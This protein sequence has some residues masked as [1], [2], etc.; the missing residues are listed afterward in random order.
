MTKKMYND[1]YVDGMVNTENLNISMTGSGML[2][3][4]TKLLGDEFL[5]FIL[6]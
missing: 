1:L 4:R 2:A 6:S 5:K 3:K